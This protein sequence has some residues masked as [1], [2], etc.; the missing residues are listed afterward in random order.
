MYKEKVLCSC[1]LICE[2]FSEI[3]L[4][5]VDERDE[6]VDVFFGSDFVDDETD[7]PS[8][9]S[10]TKL[11]TVSLQMSFCFCVKVN[12]LGAYHNSGLVPYSTE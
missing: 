4:L 9:L 11:H 2:K 6:H 3:I 1:K 7:I 5:E 8:S 12:L 10:A